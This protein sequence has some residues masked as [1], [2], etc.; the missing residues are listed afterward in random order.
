MMIRMMD[1]L[2]HAIRAGVI[3]GIVLVVLSLLGTTFT[4]CGLNLF[5]GLIAVIA[6]AGTGALAARFARRHIGGLTE[7][8]VLSGMAGAIAGAIDG[9]LH[10]V[11]SLIRPGFN[12]Y[13]IF[14]FLGKEVSALTCAPFVVFLYIVI[15]AIIAVFGGAVYA[16]LSSDIS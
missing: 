5:L 15:I 1:R 8:M 9:I 13:S 7:V 16:A 3:G 10:V 6:A 12:S 11:L 4:F 14:G 2:D